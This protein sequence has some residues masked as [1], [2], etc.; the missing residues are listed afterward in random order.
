MTSE[1]QTEVPDG[2]D[3]M[4]RTYLADR[5][6]PCPRCGYNLRASTGGRCN[7]CGTAVRLGVHAAEPFLRAWIVAT[8]ASSVGAGI[9]LL[10]VAIAL[11]ESGLPPREYWHIVFGSWA[12]LPI[13]A[14]VIA[15]RR[16]FVRL[17]AVPTQWTIAAL[18]CAAVAALL[19]GLTRVR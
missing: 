13:T 8:V 3:A 6:A 10:F 18:L 11:G 17:A 16:R 7:E 19:V 14:C 12:F 2:D 15:L 4:L 1:T 5:D 9:G